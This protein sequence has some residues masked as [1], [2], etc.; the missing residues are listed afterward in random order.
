[1]GD[2]KGRYRGTGNGLP[3]EGR[4]A[5]WLRRR[6]RDSEPEDSGRE[7]LLLAVAAAGMPLAPAAH[8]VAYRCSCERI[9][10]PTPGR[11]P[12]S[13]AWQTQSTTDAAQVRR[14]AQ[15]DPD[16]NFVTATG[17]VH[18]VL[19]V[20]LEAGRGG[21]GPRPGAGK[22]GG[23]RRPGGGARGGRPPALGTP[24]PGP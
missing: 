11:H 5:G 9:G 8:P 13:F 15:G 19:D 22:G 23:A 6:S 20:P 17:M 21:P 3:R 18:D 24:T 10:C 14:W 4:L 7:D 12:V 2:G 1:M 16:A